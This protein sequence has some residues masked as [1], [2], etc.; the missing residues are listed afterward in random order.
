MQTETV[1]LIAGQ[2]CITNSPGK[3][4]IMRVFVKYPLRCY[5][6]EALARETGLPA[7]VVVENILELTEQGVRIGYREPQ[8]YFYEP[9]EEHLDPD[10]IASR[11]DTQWWGKRIWAGEELT[12][13]IDIAKALHGRK[14]LHGMVIVA[15]RQ[16]QGRG[17]F[18]NTWVSPKGKNILLTFLIEHSEWEPPVSLLSLYAA[19]AAARVLDTAYG[20]PISL[21]WP[22]DLMV[23]GK[24]LGGVLVE[25][26]KSHKRLL[27]SLG[28]NV[29]SVPS[30]WP[31]ELRET[32]VSLAM[33]QKQEWQREELIAQCG[34][35]WETLWE[36]TMHD[37]GETVKGYW[38][39]YYDMVGK[40]VSLTV[41]GME[42]LAYAKTID[43]AGRL[44]VTG[45]D[46]AEYALL[47]EEVQKL[48]VME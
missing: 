11:L 1:H 38:K 21:K 44:V 6:L 37:H 41:R 19:T 45:Q 25:W 9:K 34:T 42:L 14:S 47:P 35:T 4:A 16:T 12:S 20:V 10:G 48:R 36:T 26:N 2:T 7:A 28:L 17:R 32:T 30:D 13:T 43:D 3:T 40:T 18:G 31:S 39:Q 22:N 23:Q 46:G 5:T 27:I 15:N 24:K 33:V 29:H 8:G